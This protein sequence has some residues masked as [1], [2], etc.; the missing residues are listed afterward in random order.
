MTVGAFAV[1]AARPGDARGMRDLVSAV[2]RE[3]RFIRRTEAE[4]LVVYRRRA[5]RS[6]T[7]DGAELVAVDADGVL[8]G[9]RIVR[10]LHPATR[11]VAS[12]GLL[13]RAEHR[14]RGIGRA[15]LAEAIRWAEHVG[16]RKLELAVYPDNDAAIALYR[17]CGFVEEGRLRGHSR[18]GDGYADEIIMG[19]WLGG[20]A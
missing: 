14:G 1:R 15:L 6:W 16:V 12:F 13:V 2:A 3:G 8:G 17:A 18:R 10:E 5:R 19:R 11:H 9:V 20:D 7:D 4:P